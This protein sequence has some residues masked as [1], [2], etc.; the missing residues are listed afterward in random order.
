MLFTATASAVIVSGGCH[1]LEEW[2]NNPQGNFEALWTILDEHYCFFAEKDVDWRE[3]HDKYAPLVSK[4]HDIKGAILR[5]RRHAR[6]T[7]RW[8]HQPVG[9]VQYLILPQMVERL[10]SELPERL[11]EQYYLNFNFLSASGPDYAVLPQN[12]GYIRYSSFSTPIGEGNLD[13]VLMYLNTCD[14]LIIDIRDN[15]GGSMTNVETL[16][17]RF[18]TSRTLAGYIS[19]KT[20]PGHNDFSEPFAYYLTPAERGRI[21]GK[22]TV[23]P[24]IERH[25]LR[26]QQLCVYYEIHPRGDYRSEPVQEEASGMPLHLNCPTDGACVFGMFRARQQRPVHR[27]RHRPDTGL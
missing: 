15:G 5:M 22:P 23:V 16:V 13:E 3:I 24:H 20:G 9:P 26:G 10:S 17:R 19:H 7:A 25:I 27:V 14:G 2:D 11:V 6:R 8:P 21:M 1:P 4:P 12:I 18:I